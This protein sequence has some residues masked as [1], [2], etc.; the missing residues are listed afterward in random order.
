MDTEMDDFGDSIDQ[1]L[2]ELLAETDDSVETTEEFDIDD[3]DDF[4]SELEELTKDLEAEAKEDSDLDSLIEDFESESD[5]LDEL[6]SE[7]ESLDVADGQDA[8]EAAL[9]GLD[10]EEPE[11]PMQ[12]E[13]AALEDISADELNAPDDGEVDIDRIMAEIDAEA[14]RQ[15]QEDKDS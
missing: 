2:D 4:D 6:L 15:N 11:P 13:L 5:D 9:E 14:M 10:E 1:A 3:L 12:D 8:L 7:G